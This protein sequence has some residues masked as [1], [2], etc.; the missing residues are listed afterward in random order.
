VIGSVETARVGAGWGTVPGAL[1]DTVTSRAGSLPQVSSNC[2][3]SVV[4]G[5][6]SVV[7]GGPLGAVPASARG[8]RTTVPPSAATA[9]TP[10]VPMMNLR[11]VKLA[12]LIDSPVF[13]PFMARTVRNASELGVAGG[14]PGGYR[15]AKSALTRGRVPLSAVLAGPDKGTAL[16]LA[17]GGVKQGC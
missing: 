2:S 12:L 15:R 9:L 11:R 4:V 14:N 8:A 13:D 7:V 17:M 3:G 1:Q 6:G 5:S 16:S 10:T